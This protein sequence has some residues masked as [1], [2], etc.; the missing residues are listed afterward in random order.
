M[1]RSW[2]G[3]D[4]SNFWDEALFREAVSDLNATQHPQFVPLRLY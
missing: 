4:A 2:G 3:G 1:S